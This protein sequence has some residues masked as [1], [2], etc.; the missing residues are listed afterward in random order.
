MKKVNFKEKSKAFFK[1]KGFVMALLLSVAAIGTSTYIATV[2]TMNKINPTT[3]VDSNTWVYPGNDQAVDNPQANIPRESEGENA[4]NSANANESA[5]D[6]ANRPI[7][8]SPV[9]MPVEG[10]IMKPFSKNE[11]VPSTTLNNW[12]T[13]DGVDIAADEGVQVKSMT[14]GTVKEVREDVLWGITVTIEHD[15]GYEGFYANLSPVV[16]VKAGEKVESGTV[17]GT[18]GKTAA[19][20][21]ADPPHLHFGLKLSGKWVDPLVVIEG[22]GNS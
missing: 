7:T 3:P 22:S 17:I 19:A 6:D 18:I 14:S 16:P 2:Q 11:F 20:E 8:T 5:V 15:N 13:H 4:N 10:E 21:I 9:I 1:G 12:K